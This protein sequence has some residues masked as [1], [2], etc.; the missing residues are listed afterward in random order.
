MTTKAHYFRIGMFVVVTTSLFVAAIVIL[1]AGAL[2]RKT[3][4]METYC[5]ESIQGLEV[6]SPVKY[7]GVKI[8]KVDTISIVNATYETKRRY[9]MITFSVDIRI[10]GLSAEANLEKALQR[11]IKSGMRIRWNPQGITG[12]AYLELDY[13]DP[14]HYPPLEIDWKPGT[15]YIPSALSTYSRLSSAVEQVFS[16]I[17]K[18]D[19]EGIMKDVDTL[20]NAL[21]KEVKDVHI[22]Q[23]RQEAVDLLAEARESNR[24]LR[25]ILDNPM[26]D[27]ITSDTAVTMA[28][29]RLVL[30]QAREATERVNLISKD[31]QGFMSSQETSRTLANLSLTTA[32]FKTASAGLPEAV[33]QWNRTMRQIDRTVSRQQQDIDTIFENMRRISENLQELTNYA[34]RYPSV[35]LFGEAPPPS[36][37]KK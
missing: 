10:L 33:L 34:K 1:G 17:E 31:V 25:Q 28:N 13:F 20:A 36:E 6:G 3:T 11:E 15:P 9:V 8:G 37:N 12:V 27:A 18:A 21:A 24:R 35:V 2:F 19:V 22:G 26:I 16:R 32:N 29:A 4:L 14:T 7:R 5:D 30:A 23:L